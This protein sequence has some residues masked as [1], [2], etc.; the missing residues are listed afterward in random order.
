MVSLC[1]IVRDCSVPSQ[2]GGFAHT[3]T[4][5]SQTGSGNSSSVNNGIHS[6]YGG[7]SGKGRGDSAEIRLNNLLKCWY[8]HIGMRMGVLAWLRD[9]RHTFTSKQMIKS[10]IRMCTLLGDM[11]SETRRPTRR[12]DFN[13][14]HA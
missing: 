7:K 10:N 1:V 3:V 13:Y 6:V 4:E 8:R 11:R 12:T 14:R 2:C 5:F 9:M